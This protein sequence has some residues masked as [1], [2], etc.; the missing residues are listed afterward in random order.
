MCSSIINKYINHRNQYESLSLA[1]FSLK[2]KI[3]KHHKPKIIRFANSNKHKDIANWP[4]KQL[5][6]YSPFQNSKNSQLGINVT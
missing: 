6:L 4:R 5:L 1:E 3:S 2:N